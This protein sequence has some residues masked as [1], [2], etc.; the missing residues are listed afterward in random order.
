METE[1][2]FNLL[3]FTES[4][5]KACLFSATSIFLIV[6]FII[7]PLSK[8]RTISI[9]MKLIALILLFY[10]IYLHNL[11]TNLLR[12]ASKKN[13]T[14]LVTNQLNINILCSYLFTLFIV[15]LI[16]FVG[17]SFF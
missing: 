4:T 16:I 10:T 9:I 7:T 14:E 8:L 12:E 11:Q 13:N 17:K 1:T 2:P 6:L 5:K 3:L 15:L